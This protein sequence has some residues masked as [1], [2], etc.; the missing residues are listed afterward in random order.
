MLIKQVA[1]RGGRWVHKILAQGELS[2]S[3]VPGKVT[4]NCHQKDGKIVQVSL[5]G[6][7]MVKTALSVKVKHAADTLGDEEAMK[8]MQNTKKL[9]ETLYE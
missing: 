9:L 5:T 7:E 8:W 4:I 3:F 1:G 2:A 6:D